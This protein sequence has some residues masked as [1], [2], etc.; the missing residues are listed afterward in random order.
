MTDRDNLA[1]LVTCIETYLDGLYDSDIARLAQVFHPQAHYVTASGA[2]LLMLD[3][4]A[5]FAVVEKRPSPRSRGETRQDQI[6][7]V[8]FAGPVTA[9]AH[10]RCRFLGRQFDD[11]LTFIRTEAGWQIISKVFHYVEEAG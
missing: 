10:V 4:P 2:S 11:F 1:A 6:V 3:M 9:R 5:Y 7:S 8:D